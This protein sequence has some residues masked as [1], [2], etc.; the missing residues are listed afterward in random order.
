MKDHLRELVDQYEGHASQRPWIA[1]EYLQARILQSLQE[2]GA[3]TEWALQGGTALRFLYSLPR[4]SEDLD[5][6]LV[7]AGSEARFGS[8]IERARTALEDEGYGV[9]VKLKEEKAV[10]TAFLR[11]A[12]L[13]FELG[14][15]P[16][17]EEVLSVRVELDTHPPAGATL[18][19]TMVRRHI[20]LHLHHHDRSTLLAGKLHAVL[21]RPWCKGRDLYDLAWYLSD[22][23]WPEPNVAFLDAALRQTGWAGPM[24]SQAN[25]RQ[26]TAEKIE[27]L[28]VRSAFEDVRPFLERPAD[29][30]MVNRDALLRLLKG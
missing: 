6:A 11:F 21:S 7:K 2:S 30:D 19:T 29:A 24:V 4:F 9:T 28:D 5:F 14:L 10:A 23:M 3:F 8:A 13:P 12:G 27:S 20:L 15:S 1:R 22:R 16:H 26:V 17:G 18:D 25:W